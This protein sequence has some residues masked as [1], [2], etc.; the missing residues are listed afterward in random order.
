MPEEEPLETG[1]Y[2]SATLFTLVASLCLV[3]QY[4]FVAWETD[5]TD[6]QDDASEVRQVSALENA[7]F[8][9]DDSQTDVIDLA[10]CVP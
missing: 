7:V 5:A 3:V 6:A 10:D 9:T 8:T 2:L 4:H 1:W